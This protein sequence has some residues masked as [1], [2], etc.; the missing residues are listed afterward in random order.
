MYSPE[1]AVSRRVKSHVYSNCGTL[2]L[3]TYCVARTITGLEYCN[4]N[5]IRMYEPK[6]RHVLPM[7]TAHVIVHS[8]IHLRHLYIH[9]LDVDHPL[10]TYIFMCIYTAVQCL[11]IPPEA[12][13]FLWKSESDCL[14]CALLLLSCCLLTLLASVFLPSSSL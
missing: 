8:V 4:Q 9:V 3:G 1:R 11:C 6:L 2:T 14:G 13:I 10:L 5:I 12:F 7:C